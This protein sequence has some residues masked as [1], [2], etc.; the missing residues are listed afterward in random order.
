MNLVSV[1]LT[2]LRHF[3]ICFSELGR[4]GR[5]EGERT[6]G[7]RKRSRKGLFPGD[8]GGNGCAL[9]PGRDCLGLTGWHQMGRFTEMSR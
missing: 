3:L 2:Y 7:R 8:M 9:R 5:W 1:L 6:L 4:A